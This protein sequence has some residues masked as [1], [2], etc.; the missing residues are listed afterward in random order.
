MF[1]GEKR[2][3]VDESCLGMPLNLRVE[4][5]NTGYSSTLLGSKGSCP[6]TLDALLTFLD[7]Q[8]RISR[9]PKNRIL[10][11]ADLI[12][13]EPV[14]ISHSKAYLGPST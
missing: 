5:K 7:E 11:I 12:V 6:L 2:V 10:T 8:T 3:A 13:V 9:A 1:V 4:I 14:E